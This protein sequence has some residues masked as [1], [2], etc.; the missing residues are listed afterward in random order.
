MTKKV[1]VGIAQ[2][3]SVHLDLQQSLQRLASIVEEASEHS[4]DLLVFGETWLS[5]YPVWLD[6]CP[7]IGFWD[8]AAMKTV[9]RKFHESSIAIPSEESRYIGSLAKKNNLTLC[10]GVNERVPAGPGN[11]TVYNALLTFGPDGELLNHHRKLVPTFTE[12][13]LYG[14]GDAQGLRSVP[15]KVGRLS[16]LVCWEHWMPL[17]RQ[18]LHNSGEDVHVAVWPTVHEKHQIAS[19]HYAIEGRCYVLAAGQLMQ[20]REIPTE[21]EL[22]LSLKEKGDTYLLSGGSCIIG[23]DGEYVIDPVFEEEC[24]VSATIDLDRVVEEQMALDTTGHYQ[25]PD[26]FHFE[27]HGK[28]P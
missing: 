20:A 3:A 22:P 26:A 7:G 21:L 18:A 6:H 15:S 12:K 8:D 5:G 25:R 24:I 27:V 17:S 4:L 28:R 23:P 9:Y 19:R 11:G 14:H 13:L 1:K 10:I 2:Y 16:G